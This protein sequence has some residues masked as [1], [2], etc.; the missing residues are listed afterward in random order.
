MKLQNQI[1]R[2]LSHPEAIVYV[3]QLLETEEAATRTELA[4]W[5]CEEF[6]FQDPR[7]KDQLGGCL[8]GLRELEAKGWFELP[9]TERQK[10]KPSPRRLAAAVPN[11]EGVP[12]E[13][14]C[15]AS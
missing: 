13:V 2:T 1:K 8:K 6:G 14:G 4:E 3:R 7:G 15:N 12:G 10:S 9:P 5:C 11:P